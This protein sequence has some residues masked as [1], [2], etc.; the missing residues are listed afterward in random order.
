[1]SFPGAESS[2]SIVDFCTEPG[3][4]SSL[5]RDC[6]VQLTSTYL[7]T[8]LPFTQKRERHSTRRRQQIAHARALTTLTPIPPHSPLVPKVIQLALPPPS[9]ISPLSTLLSPSLLLTDDAALDHLLQF[10]PSISNVLRGTSTLCLVGSDEGPAATLLHE[11]VG[12]TSMLATLLRL[13]GAGDPTLS[14]SGT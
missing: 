3:A 13:E 11:G 9:L 7:V 5:R 1:M 14:P 12:G 6:S 10:L 2:L 8:K 4:K